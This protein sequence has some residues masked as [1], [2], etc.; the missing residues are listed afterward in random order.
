M[1][2]SI[3]NGGGLPYARKEAYSYDD[4]QFQAD[5]QNGDKIKILDS[6][7]VEA[8]T[9]GEQTVFKI[10]TRNG[11]KKFAFNQKTINVLVQEFGEDTEGWANREVKVILHKGIFAGKKGIAAYLVTD[12]WQIDE[13]GEIVKSND[14]KQQVEAQGME[15]G[16]VP[17]PIDPD[18]INF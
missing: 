7:E 3:R 2:L 9:F 17:D 14:V 5:L 15:K 16:S 10:R 18:E 6:G 8:G 12:A 13:Y 4:K 11:D 1:K